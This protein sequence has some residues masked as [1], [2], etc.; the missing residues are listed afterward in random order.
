MLVYQ[1]LTYFDIVC[2]IANLSHCPSVARRVVA[3][4]NPM[5]V[6]RGTRDL[7]GHETVIQ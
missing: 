3:G 6:Q 4:I 2:E 5:Q 7:V 1:R